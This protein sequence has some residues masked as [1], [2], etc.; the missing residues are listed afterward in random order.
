MNRRDAFR[1][2]ITQCRTASCFE[3][4]QDMNLFLRRLGNGVE[5]FRMHPVQRPARSFH[6]H[7]RG[8]QLLTTDRRGRRAAANSINGRAGRC[9]G[10][11]QQ[12][13]PFPNA[14]RRGMAYARQRDVR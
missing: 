5:G 11:N 6:F 14:R 12:L 4:R 8:Y 10:A 1:G 13:S 9:G 2:K 3:A 7:L